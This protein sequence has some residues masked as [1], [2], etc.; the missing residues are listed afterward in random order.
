MAS[1]RRCGCFIIVDQL[2]KYIPLVR[3]DAHTT[4]VAD[5]SRTTLTQ[6][7]EN[8]NPDKA[9]EELRYVFP[10]YDGVSVV[11]FTCTVGSRIIRGVVKEKTKAKQ[12]YDEA[13]AQGRTAGL[14]EQCMDAADVFTTRIG[15]VPAGETVKV[16]IEY[17]GELK[18]D[19][20]ADAIRF[21]IP[22]SIAPRYGSQQMLSGPSPN[23]TPAR[24]GF[25]VTVDAEMPKGSAIRSIQSPSHPISVQIGLSSKA[26]TSDEPSLERASASLTL[27]SAEL[28]RDF[29]LQVSATNVG[30]PAAVLEAHPTIPDQRALMVSVVPKF[31]LPAERPEIVFICD[32]SG[33][34]GAGNKIPNLVSALN[35][36][37][38]SLPLGVKFN[39]CSFGSHHKF[40]WERSRTYDQ[41]TLDEAV[42]YVKNFGS[43]F[44][45]TEMYQ[46]MDQT[47]Q[48]R[49]KDMNLEVF[50]LTDGQIWNQDK[51]FDL[52]NHQV[53]KTHGAIRVFTLGIGRDA[54]HALIE[55]VARAG[56]GFAQFVGDNEKMTRKVIR[57]LKAS[58]MPHVRDY[59]LE[60]KYDRADSEDEEDFELVEKVT[61][62]LTA[63]SKTKQGQRAFEVPKRV[64]SLFNRAKKEDDDRSPAD[65][66]PADTKYDHLPQIEE[67]RYL[68]APFQ[69]PPLFPF[70][71][72]SV[73]VILPDDSPGRNPKSVLLKG[74][75][76]HGPLELEI[77][78]TKLKEEGEMIHQ[79]AAR[80][81]IKELEEGRGWIFH[82]KDRNSIKLLKDEFDGRFPDM[83]EREAVRL[84]VKYQIA[85]KWCSFVAV[86]ESGEDDD[87][88]EVAMEVVRNRVQTTDPSVLRGRGF[89]K[90]RRAPLVG[91]GGIFSSRV[92]SKTNMSSP[93][94]P[95]SSFSFSSRGAPM[96]SS[97]PQVE[98]LGFDAAQAPPPPPPPAAPLSGGEDEHSSDS[99]PGF[100]LFDGDNS[101]PAPAPP[102]T[103]DPLQELASLQSFRGSWTWSVA[104]EQALGVDAATADV[105]AKSAGIAQVGPD[106]LATACVVAYLQKKLSDEKE[107]WEMM[108]D[109]AVSWLHGQVGQ[110]Q[111]DALARAVREIV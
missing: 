63:S 11:S 28:D 86:G 81:V 4:I 3:V 6:T 38:K 111:Y 99:E 9:L 29:V 24:Q 23:V 41:T 34:M 91:G 48:R 97:V 22:T 89:P 12:V 60:V 30:E 47:F 105:A 56:N 44:G 14:L 45:G 13:K 7:F 83:V 70:N 93:Q 79:L 8:P 16:D 67:P 107:A 46:P 65:A 71:R 53:A 104:L 1:L 94:G 62:A 101:R 68:Q 98:S 106:A 96:S 52:I 108:A 10:L 36:F 78:V 82:A 57:M 33:S 64:I 95:A 75:S 40:L 58:L 15:N 69:I 92:L 73:Y 59:T 102:S 27:A 17:V 25:S 39:I 61:D 35:V 31:D 20:E 90:T 66:A 26:S 50:L 87:Q 42:A 18:H 43:D 84:G 32:R 74:T 5:A 88:A 72:T 85:G 51:L 100:A 54:S 55:G 110:Q 49:Y 103:N 21:T 19:A 80:K 37:L 77:P 2:R 109:K 76:A